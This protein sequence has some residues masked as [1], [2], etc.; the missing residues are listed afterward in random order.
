[1]RTDSIVIYFPKGFFLISAINEKI[2]EF[3]S[4]G[5]MNYWLKKYMNKRYSKP[6][7][8][9]KGPKQLTINHLV[10]ILNVYIIGCAIASAIF[11]IELCFF[12]TLE[13]LMKK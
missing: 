11:F 1:M 7:S 3:L 2:G 10:G 8:L 13:K 4:S 12:Y 6:D 5:I 9:Q